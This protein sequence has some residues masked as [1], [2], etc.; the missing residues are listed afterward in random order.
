MEDSNTNNNNSEELYAKGEGNRMQERQIL[1][2]SLEDLEDKEIEQILNKFYSS[3]ISKQEQNIVTNTKNF[4]WLNFL[5]TNPDL[6]TMYL[7]QDHI[8]EILIY[9]ALYYLNIF[10]N[11]YNER[12]REKPVDRKSGTT[13][14]LIRDTKIINTTSIKQNTVVTNTFDNST[15]N[16]SQTVIK[17]GI[18]GC[19]NVGSELL[20]KLVDIKDN[21]V[22]PYK[23]YVSTRRP[24]KITA[25]ILNRL[26]EDIE[27][28][29]DNEKVFRE[30]DI[31][32]LCIQPHQL[33]LL[34]KEIYN[35]LQ[36]RVERLNKKKHKIYPMIVSFLSATP[37]PRLKMF[38][39]EKIFLYRTCLNPKFLKTTKID[40]KNAGYEES[41]QKN[42]IKE[43][44]EHLLGKNSIDFINKFI[45]D[46]TEMVYIIAIKDKDNPE[47]RIMQEITEIPSNVFSYIIG[48]SLTEKYQHQYDIKAKQFVCEDKTE[49]IK[50][51]NEYYIKAINELL[52]LI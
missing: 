6:K 50:A 31:I 9:E 52:K 30:C 49:L 43:S 42:Y 24:D 35:V 20:K 33:D 22:Y 16:F 21:K 5:F 39:P 51:S 27:I 41:A 4:D 40:L 2:E 3:N 19:G 26:D 15:I 25:D 1:N 8:R 46:L 11:I 36:E 28:F 29:L 38:F 34:S 23:I 7:H 44:A 37:L 18:I 13:L 17:I 48:D 32:Y 47:K 45:Y 10:S 14:P 12:I